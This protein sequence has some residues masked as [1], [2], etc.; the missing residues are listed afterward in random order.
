MGRKLTPMRPSFLEQNLVP[1]PNAIHFSVTP[2]E[3]EEIIE[4]VIPRVQK[5]LSNEYANG[6]FI[7][8]LADGVYTQTKI[9]NLTLSDLSDLKRVSSVEIKGGNY[10]AQITYRMTVVHLSSRSL[11]S[12][13]VLRLS[14]SFSRWF[15]CWCFSGR[16]QCSLR[17][18]DISI[19]LL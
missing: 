5:D 9:Y 17:G 11:Q 18:Q 8:E 2:D 10:N 1:D 15:V 4:K 14:F 6:L 19:P 12:L 13:S 3:L 16:K 7:K